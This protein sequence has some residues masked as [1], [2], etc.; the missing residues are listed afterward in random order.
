[1]ND[2][3]QQSRPYSLADITFNNLLA[4]QQP[5][6]PPATD[7]PPSPSPAAA[8]APTVNMPTIEEQLEQFRQLAT[9]QQEQIDAQ[10]N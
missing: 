7:P 9:R 5:P 3:Q 8:A 4:R 6:P 1:M 2:Q 10:N